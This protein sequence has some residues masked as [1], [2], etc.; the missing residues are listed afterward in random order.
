MWIWN[1]EMV[2]PEFQGILQR[3]G[4][5]VGGDDEVRCRLFIGNVN[6]VQKGEGDPREFQIRFARLVEDP[7]VAEK[8]LFVTAILRQQCGVTP[9][10]IGEIDV[11]YFDFLNR[12][13]YEGLALLHDEGRQQLRHGIQQARVQV[14]WLDL[15][16]LARHGKSAQ[17]LIARPPNR[18]NILKAGPVLVA[19]FTQCFVKLFRVDHGMRLRLEGFDRKRV[20]ARFQ[21]R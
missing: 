8:T 4:G 3:L 5:K 18:G 6:A 1:V 2:A 19:V 11:R 7:N 17:G 9:Q 20:G 21:R 12:S 13:Q 16:V 14:M 10:R 15:P